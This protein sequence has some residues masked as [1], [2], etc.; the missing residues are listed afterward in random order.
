MANILPQFF[1]LSA[2]ASFFVIVGW[3][4]FKILASV[5]HDRERKGSQVFLVLAGLSFG[6]TW[7][8]ILKFASW[9]FHDYEVTTTL[10]DDK[11]RDAYFPARVADW[12]LNTSLFEQAWK[13]V[14][15]GSSWSWWLNQQLCL[16]TAGTWTVFLAVE[17]NKHRIK[18][19]WAYMLLGQMLTISVGVNL[20]YYAV[21]NARPSGRVPSKVSPLLWLTVPLTMAIVY[22][23]PQTTDATFGPALTLMHV[24]L[25]IPLFVRPSQ[26]DRRDA[27]RLDTR[28]FYRVVMYT[29]LA[30]H[31]HASVVAYRSLPQEQRSVS[32][33]AHAALG[34]LYSHPAQTSVGWDA[35]LTT[36][37]CGAWALYS[38]G[39]DVR[40][41]AERGLAFGL[42]TLVGS[43][44]YAAMAS[45]LDL[46]EE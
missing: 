22:Y 27:G 40:K 44:A 13:N 12:L 19:L 14:C 30:M 31:L 1:A 39:A 15:F 41:A 6:I 8:Y 17:G 29:A 2:L 7:F 36:I 18:H 28:T 38:A 45:E 24:L 34:A 20:F 4:A 43:V 25:F 16:F 10:F 21:A 32:G 37:S 42:S 26:T 46:L 23:T 5:P 35:I 33:V 11:T 9:S 3:L